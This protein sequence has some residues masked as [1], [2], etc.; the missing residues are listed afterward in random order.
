M[1]R[2]FNSVAVRLYRLRGGGGGRAGLLLTT[3]GARSGKERTVALAAFPDEEDRWLVVAALAG[4][5]RHPAWFINLARSPDHVWA[6]IGRER[7]KVR[8]EVLSGDERSA[9]WQR[10]VAV[11]P[12]FGGYQEKT[13][14]ELPVV[15]LTRDA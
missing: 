8:P 11:A 9:A 2:A 13:D 5:A 15:R 14:R 1:L 6:E 10:V 3:I 12:G 4:A 7:F